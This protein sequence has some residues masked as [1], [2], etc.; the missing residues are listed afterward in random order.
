[1]HW[2]VHRVVLRQRPSSRRERGALNS[3]DPAA[4]PLMAL[5]IVGAATGQ[6][7]SPPPQARPLPTE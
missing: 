7:V 2:G 6:D 4:S 1:M 3:D 5:E